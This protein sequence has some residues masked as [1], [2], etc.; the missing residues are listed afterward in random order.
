MK[1]WLTLWVILLTPFIAQASVKM[2]ITFDDLPAHGKLP[3]NESR[4]DI[5][6]SILKTLKSN[7][8][9]EVYG[10][11]NAQKVQKD[12]NDLE[13]LN[14]WINSG[15]PLGNHAFSHPDLNKSS[16]ADFKEEIDSN[17]PLLQKL[18]GKLN[19][20]YFRYPFLHEG[21]TLEKRNAIR[22]HLN[23]KGYV[24]AQ[25]TDDFEDWGWNDPYARCKE[26]GD[27]KSIEWLKASYLDSAEKRL[28][29]DERVITAVWHHPISH[30][31]LM[32]IGAFD[33]VMLPALLH[34]YQQK[35]IEFISLSEAVKDPIYKEDPGFTTEP[36]NDFQY[37]ILKGKGMTLKDAGIDSPYPYPGKALKALCK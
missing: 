27:L 21:D 19:W 16:A 30:I 9:P 26:K 1:N 23:E 10:F 11:I 29:R 8:V 36:G 14:L 4:M 24:V 3:P 20:H 18:S 33:A 34:L 7:H 31:L 12:K 15:Y 2:A 5:A 6:R 37:Q 25:V 22:K 32:H 17:E 28:I 35:G 13:V